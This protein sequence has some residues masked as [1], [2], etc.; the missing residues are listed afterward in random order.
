VKIAL[1]GGWIQG[2]R[3]G[4]SHSPSELVIPGQSEELL[5]TSPLPINNNTADES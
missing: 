5:S 3:D 1:D 4:C 2:L